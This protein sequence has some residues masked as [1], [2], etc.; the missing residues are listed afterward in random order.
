M[1]GAFPPPPV[2]D[3]GQALQ[4]P[5]AAELQRLHNWLATNRPADLA[6]ARSGENAVDVA[7]RLLARLP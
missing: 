3:P 5:S 4:D 6:A 1:N 7:L 2:S